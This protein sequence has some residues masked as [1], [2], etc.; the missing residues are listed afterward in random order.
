MQGDLH[1]EWQSVGYWTVQELVRLLSH[2]EREGARPLK[3]TRAAVIAVLGLTGTALYLALP[4]QALD[5]KRCA[6][7]MPSVSACMR[8]VVQYEGD[9]YSLSQRTHWCSTNQPG[10]YSAWKAAQKGR[11]PTK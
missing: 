5:C 10:C 3:T 6:R 1:P 11:R 2:Q 9:K 8:C 7:E 4:T